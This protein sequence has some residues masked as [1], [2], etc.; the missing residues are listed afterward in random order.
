MLCRDMRRAHDYDREEAGLSYNRTQFPTNWEPKF[1]LFR[2][3]TQNRSDE[4]VVVWT[5]PRT[6]LSENMSD[7]SGEWYEKYHLLRLCGCFAMIVVL[8][9]LRT[10][11]EGV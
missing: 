2:T 11:M 7:E 4:N 10:L 8:A 6:L 1:T 5:G 3:L 9:L